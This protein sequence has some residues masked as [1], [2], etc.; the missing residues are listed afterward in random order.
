MRNRLAIVSGSLVTL[1]SICFITGLAIVV[2]E[3][4]L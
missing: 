1:A 4:G 2:S 3:R